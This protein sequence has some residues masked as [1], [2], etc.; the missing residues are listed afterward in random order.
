M[1]LL[2]PQELAEYLKV[3]K[4]CVYNWVHLKKIPYT[5]IGGCIRFVMSDIEKWLI[6]RTRDEER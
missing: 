6:E 5:K 4:Q 1:T 2:T 3:G